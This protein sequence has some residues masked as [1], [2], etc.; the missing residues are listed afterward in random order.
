MLQSKTGRSSNIPTEKARLRMAVPMT[1]FAF[2][3]GFRAGDIAGR[4]AEAD[5]GH[6]SLQ[7]G[8]SIVIGVFEGCCADLP[9][10]RLGALGVPQ[11]AWLLPRLG[12]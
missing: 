1:L 2:A 3:A 7:D 8:I 4:K 10:D 5:C 9:V 12:A 6:V 11:G